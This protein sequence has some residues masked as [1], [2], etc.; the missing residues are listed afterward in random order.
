[1]SPHYVGGYPNTDPYYIS[2]EEEAA[3]ANEPIL[4]PETDLMTLLSEAR[5]NA[6]EEA[7]RVVDQCNR[8]GPYN[9]IGAASRIRALKQESSAAERD[10]CGR[11]RSD[12]VATPSPPSSEDGE[13]KEQALRKAAA[14]YSGPYQDRKR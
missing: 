7:A 3:M 12:R 4:S 10:G 6:L 5:A 2:P 8:E 14:Y 11:E 13:T 1:M 9:A